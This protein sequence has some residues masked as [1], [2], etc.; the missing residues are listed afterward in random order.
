MTEKVRLSLRLPALLAERLQ[1]VAD[2]A[3]ITAAQAANALLAGA[4]LGEGVEANDN[5]H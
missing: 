4:L 3:G 5:N 2:A 1:Q